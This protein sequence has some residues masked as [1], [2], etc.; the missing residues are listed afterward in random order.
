MKEFVV[1]LLIHFLENLLL[2]SPLLF[3][4]VR[5]TE[6]HLILEQTI[7]PNH[8]EEKTMEMIWKLVI[9]ALAIVFI[10]T[11]LQ[12]LLF[13]TYN[14]YGHPW[15]K[16]LVTDAASVDWTVSVDLALDVVSKNDE[17]PC[18]TTD[19]TLSNLENDDYKTLERLNL[20]K[21]TKPD[22]KMEEGDGVKT[23]IQS[24]SLD[25]AYERLEKQLESLRLLIESVE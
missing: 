21:E 19:T 24:N 18:S 17:R 9:G 5:A 6:R 15:K 2:V 16:F 23:M 11:P 14:Y 20:G 12:F 7:G 10:S 8:L 3:L 4:Y 22:A 1:S 25:E 13:W